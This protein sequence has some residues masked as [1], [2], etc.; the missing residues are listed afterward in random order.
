MGVFGEGG[1]EGFEKKRKKN[2]RAMDTYNSMMIAGQEVEEA[3][4]GIN[5]DGERR[6]EKSKFMARIKCNL[7]KWAV[8]LR[9]K[10][11]LYPSC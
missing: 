4:V 6:K 5:G 1:G 11:L 8:L 3:I 7:T 2:E 10:N 9:S